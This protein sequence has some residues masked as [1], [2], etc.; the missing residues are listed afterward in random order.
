MKCVVCGI[1]LEQPLD[2]YNEPWTPMC[3]SC[4]LWYLQ[5]PNN[6]EEPMPKIY[7]F[8]EQEIE[9]LRSTCVRACYRA[10]QNPQLARH[11]LEETGC[12]VVSDAAG[13]E[14][15][16]VLRDLGVWRETH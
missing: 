4:H 11:N 2:V 6:Q 13:K 8:T 10:L 15:A 14:F 16:Q 1:T 5:G 9:Y 3:I 12:E 7:T